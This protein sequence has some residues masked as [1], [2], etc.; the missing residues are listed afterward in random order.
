MLG[1]LLDWL[2]WLAWYALVAGGWLCWW[3]ANRRAAQLERERD[4]A[5]KIRW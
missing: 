3:R 1:W 2:G 5:L 4:M